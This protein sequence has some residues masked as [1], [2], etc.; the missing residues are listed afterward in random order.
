M[1]KDIVPNYPK[2][3]TYN[4]PSEFNYLTKEEQD[5]L[6]DWCDLILKISTINTKHTSYWLKHLF[7]RSRDGFYISNGTFKGAMLK[8]GF[9]YASTDSGIN[10]MFNISE[11]SLKQLV[12]RDR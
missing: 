4:D 6:L 10:W 12:A 3:I 1:S 2:D 11:K 7:S 5:I 8:L 9:K